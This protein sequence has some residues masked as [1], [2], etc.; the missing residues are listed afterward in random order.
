MELKV[1]I[2]PMTRHEIKRTGMTKK[3]KNTDMMSRMGRV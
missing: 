1:P 3:V 2:D